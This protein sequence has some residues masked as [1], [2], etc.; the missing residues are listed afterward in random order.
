MLDVNVSLTRGSFTLHGEI[1][2]AGS[3]FLSGLNGSGKSSLMNI[4]AGNLIPDAGYVKV[5]QTNITGLPVEQRGV[6]LVNPDSFIPHLD[7]EKHLRWG[8]GAKKLTLD[9]ASVIETKELLGIDYAGRVDK[10]SLG[11]R[12]RVA[13][14]TALL[15]RPKVLLVD[16]AFSNI[17]NR[18]AF[19]QTFRNVCVGRS[20]DLV[21]T[22][23]QKADADLSD[24]HYEIV[25][26]LTSREF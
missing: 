6:V 2:D 19:I 3:I 11:M 4:I 14:A 24:H 26:G 16:E 20:V 15:S 17:D 5:N 18:A 8:A 13:L 7:V 10:L 9:E 1:H 12:E 25:K 22:T 23:Q 21:H